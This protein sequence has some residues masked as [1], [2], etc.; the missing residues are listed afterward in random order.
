MA[1]M[2]VTHIFTCQKAERRR[3]RVTCPR[4]RSAA[5]GHVSIWLSA[6]RIM[7]GRAA[8]MWAPASADSSHAPARGRDNLHGAGASQAVWDAGMQSRPTGVGVQTRC[9]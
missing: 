8:V 9:T 6:S 1:G 7:A 2:A 5:R 3:R 4:F